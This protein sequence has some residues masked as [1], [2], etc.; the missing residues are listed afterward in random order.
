MKNP[1]EPC[2]NWLHTETCIQVDPK[3][4]KLSVM[5]INKKRCVTWASNQVQPSETWFSPPSISSENVIIL[6]YPY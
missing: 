1:D 3:L 6:Y 4:R 5:R 2:S